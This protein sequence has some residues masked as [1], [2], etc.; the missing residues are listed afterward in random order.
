M[1]GGEDHRS[2]PAGSDAS[3]R[4]VGVGVVG[5]GFMG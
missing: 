3:D 1:S 4:I 5:L 2:P